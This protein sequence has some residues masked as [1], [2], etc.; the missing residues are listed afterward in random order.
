MVFTAQDQN[1]EVTDS[2]L[3]RKLRTVYLY[4]KNAS[5]LRFQSKN[6]TIFYRALK[7]K[8]RSSICVSNSDTCFVL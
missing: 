3:R 4:F 1:H 8:N 7:E 2:L 5:D 6:K